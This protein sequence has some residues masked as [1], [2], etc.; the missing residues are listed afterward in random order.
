M[1][2]PLPWKIEERVSQG[3]FIMGNIP[4]DYDKTVCVM[5]WTSPL[6]PRDIKMADAEFIVRAVNSYADLLKA[7]E[8]FIEYL[9]AEWPEEF[10]NDEKIIPEIAL[11]RK[12]IDKAKS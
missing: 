2:T 5:Q 8:F 6:V 7:C 12:A 10:A 11:A 4:D 3:I 9:E 1:H